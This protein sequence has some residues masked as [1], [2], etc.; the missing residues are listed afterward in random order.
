VLN[1]QTWETLQH[2]AWAIGIL[3]L[4][5][6]F[7]RKKARPYI[8]EIAEARKKIAVMWRDHGYEEWDG[9]ERRDGYG[10]THIDTRGTG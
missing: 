4:V 2:V 3:F 1:P 5:Y 6:K 8:R 10:E 7:I 9:T